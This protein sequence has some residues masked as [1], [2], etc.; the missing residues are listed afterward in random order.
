MKQKFHYSFSTKGKM[1]VKCRSETSSC[2]LKEP[3]KWNLWR[4]F[5][6][7]NIRKK[8]CFFP[9]YCDSLMY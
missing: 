5:I 7:Q 4:G 9:N 2:S 6:I 3:L 8:S 1:I